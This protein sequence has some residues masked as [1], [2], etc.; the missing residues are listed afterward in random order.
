MPLISVLMPAYN[1]ELYIKEAVD[2]ILN[3]T[4]SDFEFIIYND[5]SIDHTDEIIQSY[6]DK[7]ILYINNKINSGY[8]DLLNEG[9]SIAK[10]KYIARMDADDISL[11]NRLQVQ[12]NYLEEHPDVGICGSWFEYMGVQSGIEKRP[13]TFEE[14]QYH[15]FYGCPLTHPT[16]MMRNEFLK[17]YDLKYD[18]KYYYAEDHDL[19]FRGSFHF[20]LVNLPLVLLKYRIHATQIGSAKWMQQFHVKK[21]IQAK[22]F[23][24]ILTPC[25]KH[26]MEWLENYFT[27]QS[28]PNE[29]WIYEVAFYKNKI[30]AENEKSLIYPHSMLLKVVNDLYDS[31]IKNTFY[32]Y[33]FRKYYNRKVFKFSLLKSFMKEKYKPYKYLG[34][35]LTLFFIIKCL[36]NY[37][38]KNTISV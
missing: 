27:E 26:D 21:M 31:K 2:S 36:V 5:G 7:R 13:V 28:I 24:K 22:I 4:L 18:Q 3:Q 20:K 37:K 35:K 14:I 16:V 15:L 12:F 6:N 38:K 30:I 23:A 25:S 11:P 17:K 9:L 1:A 33:Y 32:K 8:L 10:G 34:F 29:G 19:F